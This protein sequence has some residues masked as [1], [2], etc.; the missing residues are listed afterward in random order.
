MLRPYKERELGLRRVLSEVD[1]GFGFDD[2][3][4]V[5]VGAPGGAEFLAG[6]VEGVGED[7]EDDLAFE[8][9]DVR[10]KSRA[11]LRMYLWQETSRQAQQGLV[12][13]VHIVCLER[14]QMFR[15]G[16]RCVRACLWLAKLR[17]V[18]PA[19]VDVAYRASLSG[20]SFVSVAPVLPKVSRIVVES[21]PDESGAVKFMDALNP[22]PYRANCVLRFTPRPPAGP[23]GQSP[24]AFRSAGSLPNR[25][26]FADSARIRHWS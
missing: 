17:C 15:T 10:V 5:G 25:R 13:R 14:P 22:G 26:N 23:G 3:E 20:S 1:F 12:R 18:L 6:V 21:R 7:G 24:K 11:G 8:A 9:A 4:G 19:F 16:P 2:E